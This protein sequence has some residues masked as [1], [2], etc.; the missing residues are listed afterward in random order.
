MQLVSQ[1]GS[2]FPS[3]F[4]LIALSSAVHALV[5]QLVSEFFPAGLSVLQFMPSCCSWFPSFSA[6][7]P[8]WQHSYIV[9]VLSTTRRDAGGSDVLPL[10]NEKLRGDPPPP[11]SP[12]PTPHALVRL[13][14]DLSPRAID[15]SIRSW[16]D[17][18][19]KGVWGK[20]RSTTRSCS[21]QYAAVTV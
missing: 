5:L 4:Q 13:W 10:G 7:L 2:W 3:F 14:P 20:C 8:V 21:P 11:Q 6:G 12:F 9:P 16:D 1:F 18:R 17:T 19:I 15:W